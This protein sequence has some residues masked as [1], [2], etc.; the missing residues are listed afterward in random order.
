MT[1]NI[2]F[3]AKRAFHNFRGLGNYSRT[4]LEGL[5]KYNPQ[6]HYF[7]YT[8]PFKNQRA[9]DWISRYPDFTVRTPVGPIEKKA[10]S[11]WRSFTLSKKIQDDSLDL[12]HGLSHEIPF[13]IEK[14]NCKK[15][16]TI[17][18]LLF[19]RYPENFSWVDRKMYKMKFSHACE[20]SDLVIA[21]CEQTKRDIIDFLGIKESKIKVVYQSCDPMFYQIMN[22]EQKRKLRAKYQ[23]NNDY[24]LYVGA[25][26][27]NKNAMLALEAFS[28]IASSIKENFVLVGKGGSYKDK[29]KNK[30]RMLGLE[31]RVRFLDELEYMD[32][33]GIYQEAKIFLHPSFF[34]G[35]G[36]PIVEALFSET[37]VLVTEGHCF[38]EA[39]GDHS[40][41]LNPNRPDDWAQAM[42]QM[43]NDPDGSYLMASKGRNFVE[44]FHQKEATKNLMEIYQ[45][46]L[47]N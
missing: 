40:I 39:G 12:F 20:K 43:L 19:M 11:L 8:P 30:V 21:I 18:D 31:N 27:P 23:L 26:E 28:K 13:G 10:H 4:L 22:D 29:V 44:K 33:P 2:G 47:G 41:Y 34:E 24:I 1:F 7:L 17:H 32:L 35:F 16:V 42:E 9:V 38:P 46:T 5:Y 14:V 3:D 6:G 15:I 37:P 25:I 36:I 45:L